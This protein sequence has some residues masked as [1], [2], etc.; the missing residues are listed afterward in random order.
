MSRGVDGNVLLIPLK[1]NG[2]KPE[3]N[4]ILTKRMESNLHGRYNHPV[5]PLIVDFWEAAKFGTI[6]QLKTYVKGG[7]DMDEY[8]VMLP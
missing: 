4:P 8:K 5:R 2:Y 3:R 6:K 7:Q 1:E